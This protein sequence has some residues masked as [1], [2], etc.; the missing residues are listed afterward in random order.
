MHFYEKLIKAGWEID[1]VSPQG[2]Y[3]PIDP[4]S[5]GKDVMTEADWHYYADPVFR[6]KLGSTLKP[7]EVKPENYQAIYYAGGHGVV[8]DFPE[9]KELQ[10]IAE[11]IYKKGGF[12]TSVCHG[13]VGLFHIKD[14]KG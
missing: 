13:A 8:W 10:Q 4:V 1:F 5:L 14:D 7:S 11:Q 3:T 12:V 9:N 2:G 6:H